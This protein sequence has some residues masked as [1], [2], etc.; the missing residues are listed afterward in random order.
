MLANC[1]RSSDSRAFTPEDFMPSAGKK[2]QTDEDMVKTIE[3]INRMLGGNV[4]E[5]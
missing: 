4:M 3:D 5:R 1:F 2:E